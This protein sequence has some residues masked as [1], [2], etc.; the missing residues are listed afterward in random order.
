MNLTEAGR[1]L[2]ETHRMMSEAGIVVHYSSIAHE[3]AKPRELSID[4][5]GSAKNRLI[6]RTHI[7]DSSGPLRPFFYVAGSIDSQGRR[8]DQA[9]EAPAATEFLAADIKGNFDA[10]MG[11]KE[12]EWGSRSFDEQ[13]TAGIRWYKW[14]IDSRQFVPTLIRRDEVFIN[15]LIDYDSLEHARLYH[16]KLEVGELDAASAL[17][18][19]HFPRKMFNPQLWE[20]VRAVLKKLPE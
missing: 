6:F 20:A 10:I 17:V 2:V 15:S 8:A 13:M 7:S 5:A 3:S 1:L 11:C 16:L 19:I 18:L 12:P 4:V 14:F 9:F